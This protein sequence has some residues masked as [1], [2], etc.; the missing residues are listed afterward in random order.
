[1]LRAQQTMLYREFKPGARLQSW[2]AAYWHFRVSRNVEGPLLHTIPLTGAAMLGAS[3]SDR[4]VA[5]TGPRTKPLQVPVRAGD[6]FWGAHFVPGA[7]EWLLGRV[8][9]DAHV[10]A[11]AFAA[12]TWASAMLARL[13]HVRT[14]SSARKALDHSLGELTKAAPSLDPHVMACIGLIIA[15]SGSLPIAE[16]ATAVG[17]SERQLRRRFR[18]T[19]SLSPKEFARV[20]RA[21]AAL[22]DAAHAALPRWCEIALDR[23]FAD[24]AHLIAEFRRT[25]GTTP[26][27]M[28]R[29]VR[30]IRHGRVLS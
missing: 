9:R 4:W 12:P 24:Q 18:A 1:M 30:R 25:L 20:R 22:V 5:V 21:R 17:L 2:V 16:V 3:M 11:Q 29:H 15:S 19:T 8:L 7:A 27:S 13:D 10:P 23:G 6:E 28:M 14:L 26:R